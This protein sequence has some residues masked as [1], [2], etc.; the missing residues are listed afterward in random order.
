MPHQL[1]LDGHMA[2]TAA[3]HPATPA[4]P[5]RPYQ[6]EAI[7]A[8]NAAEMTGV[9]RSLIALPT[10]CH[11]A[12]QEILMH[13]GSIW[14]VEDVRVGDRLMG[15]DGQ[16]RMVLALAR[17][18]GPMMEIRPV[19]GTPWVVNDEHILTLVETQEKR[20]GRYPSQRGGTIR[21]V[22]LPDWWQWSKNRKHRHKL[23][24][25]PVDFPER[26]AP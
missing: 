8:V 25:V 16:P 17:G 3:H 2:R 22:A 21:D 1:T 4:L 9:T 7:D 19:K 5:L 20:H 6:R 23:F 12:G 14:P 18:T 24:H 13:D 10:G 15:P 11:R 26:E